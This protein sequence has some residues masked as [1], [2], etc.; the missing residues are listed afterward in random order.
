MNDN[1]DD[2]MQEIG[3][4][5]A[6]MVRY[7][8]LPKYKS[9]YEIV[10]NAPGN[11]VVIFFPVESELDGHYVAMLYYPE[12]NSLNYFCPYGLSPAQDVSYSTFLTTTDPRVRTSLEGLLGSFQQAGGIVRVN[13][14]KFQDIRSSSATCGRHCFMRIMFKAVKEPDHYAKFLKLRNCTPDEIVTTAFI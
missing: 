14:T 2:L 10:A 4:D 3:A 7:L 13:K 11:N 9:L 6:A 5:K 12:D 8:D 1:D